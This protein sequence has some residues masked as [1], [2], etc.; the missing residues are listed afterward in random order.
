MTA[1]MTATGA[2]VSGDDHQI[3]EKASTENMDQLLITFEKD[4]TALQACQ[5]ERLQSSFALRQAPECG[6]KAKGSRLN[7]FSGQA[8]GSKSAHYP[9]IPFWVSTVLAANGRLFLE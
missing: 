3:Y 2:G 5:R 8:V 1:A 4:K 9:K 6:F 7:S